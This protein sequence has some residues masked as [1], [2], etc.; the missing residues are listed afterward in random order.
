MTEF[1]FK[2][3]CAI[4]TSFIEVCEEGN[5]CSNCVE[6]WACQVKYE[7]FCMWREEWGN[8][9]YTGNQLIVNAG[10]HRGLPVFTEGKK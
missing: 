4:N 3:R 6:A 9:F 7:V 10:I 1:N 2:G 8:G 5:L